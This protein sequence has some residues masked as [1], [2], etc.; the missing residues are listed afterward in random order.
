MGCNSAKYVKVVEDTKSDR[1]IRS[2]L[3]IQKW[4][5]RYMA[6]LEARRRCTWE[7]FQSI[8]YAGEQDQLKLYNF[9][10]DMLQQMEPDKCGQPKILR[11]LSVS[12]RPV[13]MDSL[14]LE[15]EDANI[16]R[17]SNPDAITVEP[18]YSGPHITFPMTYSQLQSLIQAIKSKKRLH[19]K[20]LL[21]LLLE[22]REELKKLGNINQATTSI[23]HKITVCGDLHG[24][25]NDL[26]MIF[27]KNGLPSVDNPYI[28]NGDFVD[29][30]SNSV[31]IVIILFASF[32]LYPNEMYINRGNHEDHIMNIRYGFVKEINRKYPAHAT[33]VLRL[34]EDVFSWLPIATLIDR[35]L[36]VVHGGISD[37][38]SLSDI[39]KIDRHKFLSILHPPREDGDI[40]KLTEN[41]IME[42]KT[43]L[44]IMWSDP[45]TQVGCTPNSFRGG[46]VYFGCNVTEA[47][48]SKHQLQ[49]IIRS[50]ECKS[51]GYEFCHNQK[52]LTVFSAS[53]YYEYGSN[54][55]AYLKIVGRDLQYN[56]VQ[57]STTKASRRKITFTQRVSNFESSAI[58]DLREKILASRTQFVQEF[59]KYD[60]KVTGKVT[61]KEWCEVMEYVMRMDLPW[62]SLRSKLVKDDP[63]T[64]IMVLYHT[65]FDQ[66]HLYHRYTGNG[67][68]LTEML[69]RNKDNL[70]TIFRILDRDNSGQISMEEFEETIKMLIK[71]QGLKVPERDILDIAH[72][73]DINKDGSIDFNE[74]LEA[75]RI[76]DHFGINQTRRRMDSNES[77]DFHSVNGSIRSVN[78]SPTDLTRK[79]S[80]KVS[81]RTSLN[82]IVEISASNRD[83]HILNDNSVKELSECD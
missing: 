63:G 66:Y 27:H 75:F 11:A 26:F 15:A 37:T 14:T 13:S 8:E 24:K 39:A 81:R 43:M 12:K 67:P 80:R 25:L 7:I 19:V 65:M 54:R 23:S 5:R 32:L 64:D 46:G 10:N 76:V 52:V 60:K 77:V 82:E 68:T 9:F 36:L 35:K 71:H 58:Q 28:F 21:E 42:W 2:A 41:E 38:T 61:V 74:F 29:R 34:F 18:M 3:L 79:V 16:Y 40:T 45:R 72:S 55:G 47:F 62:R 51:D 70:E 53:N 6:R 83:N 73:I 4:Y 20:Y 1:V 49:G 78:V 56:L 50:H 59:E 31:E 30:G 69:Y 33:M 48:L 44:D 17:L 57:Y 22:T